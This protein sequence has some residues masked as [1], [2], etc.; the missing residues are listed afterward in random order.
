MERPILGAALVTR[1]WTRDGERRKTV[2]SA[3]VDEGVAPKELSTVRTTT[4]RGL[5]G[6]DLDREVGG[7]GE[8]LFS[9]GL[10]R[11]DVPHPIEC[12][13]HIEF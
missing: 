10:D 2:V 1:R 9:F 5:A 3:V 12:R 13:I 4:K 7:N 8:D 6:I 11:D